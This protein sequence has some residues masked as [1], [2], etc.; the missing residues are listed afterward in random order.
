MSDIKA[1]VVEI[2]TEWEWDDT[3]QPEGYDANQ[4]LAD[5]LDAAG[6]LASSDLLAAQAEV[7]RLRDAL[8]R[9]KSINQAADN[10]AVHT[11]PI[12]EMKD[13][14][15]RYAGDLDDIGEIVDEALATKDP[16]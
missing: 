11:R 1:R 9:V 2:V 15:F 16:S 10:W 4:D 5:R 8:I 6:L 3:E 14:A 13:Q 12:P 7:T